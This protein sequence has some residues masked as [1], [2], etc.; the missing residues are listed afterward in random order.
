MERGTQTVLFLRQMY[1]ACL[2]AA[3]ATHYHS[4]K[5]LL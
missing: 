5:T 3:F 2:W 1:T 4:V